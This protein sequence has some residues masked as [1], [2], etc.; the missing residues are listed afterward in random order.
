MKKVQAY[1]PPRK[2]LGCLHRLLGHQLNHTRASGVCHTSRP[3]SGCTARVAWPKASSAL[4][5]WRIWRALVMW[6]V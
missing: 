2:I 3:L 4:R 6:E 5:A 1:G